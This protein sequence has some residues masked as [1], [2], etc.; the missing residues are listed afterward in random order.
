MH[1]LTKYEVARALGT[2]CLQLQDSDARR[3]SLEELLAGTSTIVI[4]RRMPD[5]AVEDVA[6]ANAILPD[7]LRAE[8]QYTLACME[9]TG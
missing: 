3:T 8:L 4:R 5:G 2:R 7:H 9:P 1:V 6:V